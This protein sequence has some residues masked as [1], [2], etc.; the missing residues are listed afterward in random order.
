MKKAM[1]ITTK[2]FGDIEFDENMLIHFERGL[3]GFE[4]MTKFLLI[5]REEDLF[6]WLTSVDQP[7]IVFPLIALDILMDDYPQVENHE[8]FGVVKLDKNPE[9][10]TVNLK[11]P[12]YINQNKK[13]GLQKIQDSDRLPIDYNLFTVKQ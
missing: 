4:E 5:T 2:Q 13:I 7:E 12:I 9:N 3:I 6:Y 8:S 10:V 1:K 11:A